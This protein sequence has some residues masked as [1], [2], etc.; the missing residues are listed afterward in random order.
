MFKS[1]QELFA[2]VQA[3]TQHVPGSCVQA[4]FAWFL[5]QFLVAETFFAYLYYVPCL[6][7]RWRNCSV[8]RQMQQ[9]F[10][11]KNFLI[12]RGLY[13]IKAAPKIS[14]KPGGV[15]WWFIWNQ[16]LLIFSLGF[17]GVRYWLS[18]SCG[19]GVRSISSVTLLVALFAW[20]RVCMHVIFFVFLAAF[21]ARTCKYSMNNRDSGQRFPSAVYLLGNKSL[22]VYWTRV[23]RG[24]LRLSQRVFY[25]QIP[26]HPF[27]CST[28]ISPGCGRLTSREIMTD[29][30]VGP[31]REPSE[32]LYFPL[33]SQN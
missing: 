22:L 7:L 33:K 16:I 23:V 2:K 30:F 18:I 27:T 4:L 19:A 5:P 17:G 15:A 12:L 14:F 11:F 9:L 28:W 8:A 21:K 20:S 13:N 1:L 31:S 32:T 29:S 26:L 10:S 6:V 24:V 3:K 25:I